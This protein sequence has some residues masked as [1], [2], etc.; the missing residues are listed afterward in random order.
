MKRLD[1]IPKLCYQ[2][3]KKTPKSSTYVDSILFENVQ[4]IT[5][6]N[7]FDMSQDKLYFLRWYLNVLKIAKK[8]AI[9]MKIFFKNL[10][11]TLNTYFYNSLKNERNNYYTRNV[12]LK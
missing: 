9:K 8:R 3:I 10:K 4:K 2:V 7:V 6:Y 5:N 12:F 1:Q 11:N